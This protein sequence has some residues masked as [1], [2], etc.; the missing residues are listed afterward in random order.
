[1]ESVLKEIISI[2]RNDSII[3]NYNN[4]NRYRLVLHENDGTSS[5]YYFSTP[6]YNLNTRKILDF[7]FKEK[8]NIFCAEGSN[9]NIVVSDSILIKKN[10]ECLNIALS[11]RA[12][13]VSS[14][15]I[16]VDNSSVFLS[17]NG[18]VIKCPTNES[19]ISFIIDISEPFLNVKSNDKYVALMKERLKP[20]A[21][22]SCIGSVDE[23]GNIISPANIYCKKISDKKY[24]IFISAISPLAHSVL[25]EANIYENKLFQDTTVESKNPSINNV[26]G[27]VAFLGET[28][29]FGEQQLYSRIDCSKIPEIMNKQIKKMTLHIPILNN[30]KIELGVSKASARFC[31]IG[32]NWNNKISGASLSSKATSFGKLYSIDLMPLMVDA[33]KKTIKESDGFILKSKL[34]NSG[35]TVIST[36]DSYYNPQILE[37]NYI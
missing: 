5:A 21:V 2:R 9:T 34:H 36:G 14:K 15:E 22:F 24:E 25:F 23:T 12:K 1:M 16:R 31:S 30:H 27:S 4:N 8:N 11:K 37:V 33:R 13:M 20:F 7:K 10:K 3:I 35:F 28:S 26:F 18:V 19:A 29:A 6:V 17:S 32:S